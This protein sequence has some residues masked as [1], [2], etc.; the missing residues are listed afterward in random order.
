[1]AKTYPSKR[2]QVAS[3]DKNNCY[4]KN[5]FVVALIILIQL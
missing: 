3:T 5:V 4:Y 1:M 2:Q